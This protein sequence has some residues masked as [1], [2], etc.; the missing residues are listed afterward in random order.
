MIH[1]I[2]ISS[3]RRIGDQTQMVRFTESYQITE[4]SAQL[5]LSLL[6]GVIFSRK[7]ISQSCNQLEPLSISRPQLEIILRTFEKIVA[8]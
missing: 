8:D 3:L 1:L 2:K 6:H 4:E 7:S 5:T